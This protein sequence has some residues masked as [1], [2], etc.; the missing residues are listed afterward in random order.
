VATS[1]AVMV[2]IPGVVGALNSV[3]ATPAESVDD[4]DAQARITWTRRH[5]PESGQAMSAITVAPVS[6][7]AYAKPRRGPGVK[8]V[9]ELPTVT[10]K[11]AVATT[12]LP[13]A[14]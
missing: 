11:P 4:L 13:A 12:S 2:Q 1:V 10:S 6:P 3:V 5:V 8:T 7:E 9:Q 14:T